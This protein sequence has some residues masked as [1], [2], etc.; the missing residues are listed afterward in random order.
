MQKYDKPLE[1]IAQYKIGLDKYVAD[2]DVIAAFTHARNIFFPEV[3]RT[4]Q[5]VLDEFFANLTEA[6]KTWNPA[7]PLTLERAIEAGKLNNPSRSDK[8]KIHKWMMENE[9]LQ[10]HPTKGESWTK[11]ITDQTTEQTKEYAEEAA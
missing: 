1:L 10:Y 2:K 3:I 5:E 4:V 6:L 7:E 9:L 8:Q 11:R